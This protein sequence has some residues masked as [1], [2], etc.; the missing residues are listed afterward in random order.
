MAGTDD[1][2]FFNCVVKSYACLL[3][4]ILNGIKIQTEEKE[5]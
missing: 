2:K 4:L 3:F 1:T 5:P